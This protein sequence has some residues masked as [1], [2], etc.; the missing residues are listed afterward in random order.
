MSSMSNACIQYAS[1]RPYR[2]E[3]EAIKVVSG[4]GKIKSWRKQRER[5]GVSVNKS[6]S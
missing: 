5:T 1:V 2:Q 6:L 4:A 3:G